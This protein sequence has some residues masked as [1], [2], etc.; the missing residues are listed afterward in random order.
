MRIQKTTRSLAKSHT[1]A[2]IPK[3]G[4]STSKIDQG[5]ATTATRL[6]LLSPRWKNQRFYSTNKRQTVADQEHLITMTVIVVSQ[7]C[8]ISSRQLVQG[9]TMSQTRMVPL[10]T[11]QSSLIKS[12]PNLM[13]FM[14]HLLTSHM[15]Y[16]I[17][18]QLQR[19]ITIK[20]QICRRHICKKIL[21][22]M[23]A[24]IITL[25]ET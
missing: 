17:S 12:I 16:L 23:D 19:L 8:K 11:T 3:K 20:P 14:A 18:N 2:I 15:L 1:Q 10:K 4:S 25:I 6:Q 13:T 21:L 24:R 5:P 9:K 22:A 7:W